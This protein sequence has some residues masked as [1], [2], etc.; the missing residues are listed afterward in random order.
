MRGV[1]I[2]EN[3]SRGTQLLG[4]KEL[5]ENMWPVQVCLGKNCMPS[6]IHHICVKCHE[7]EYTD[8]N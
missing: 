3:G 5:K 2:Q 8:P 7:I 4:L 1:I 6:H